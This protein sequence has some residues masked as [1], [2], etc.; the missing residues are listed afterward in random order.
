[1]SLVY[2]IYCDESCHLEHDHQPIMILGAIS[3]LLEKTPFIAKRIREIKQKHH[4]HPHFEIKWT[5]VSPAKIAFYLDIVDYFFDNDELAF[6]ALIVKK[7]DQLTHYDFDQDHDLWYYKMYFVML[8]AILDPEAHY[9]IY[10]D[11]KD[12]CGGEKIRKLHDVLSNNLYDFSKEIVERI[13]LVRSDE[14][15]ILQVCDLL[16]G[17]VSYINRALSTSEAKLQLIERI[18]ERSG[19]SLLRSTLLK[20]HKLNLFV[21]SPHWSERL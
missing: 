13:Q 7:K 4:L 20:E 14:I 1:M 15:E 19:Y 3:C 6:R 16:I 17:A 8:K 9:R 2:N 18:C 10:L 11:I 5:K 12:T 21:W